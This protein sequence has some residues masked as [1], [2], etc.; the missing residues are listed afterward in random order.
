M[1]GFDQFNLR[2]DVIQG[3]DAMR[4]QNPTPIQIQAIPAIME[5]RD[6]MGCAQ[7]GTGKTAAYILPVL[8]HLL[9]KK[10]DISKISTL[11]IVPT[12]ELALQI[13]QQLEGFSYFLNIS[14]ISVY[15]GGDSGSWEQQKTALT[16]GVEIVI[17]TPGRL[18][19]HLN[20]GYVDFTNL[21]FLILDEADRMLDMGFFDDIVKIL[22]FLPLKRQNLM[23]SATMPP[24]IKKL[25]RDILVNPLHINI[26]ASKPAEGVIQAVY[27]L[28]ENQKLDKISKLFTGKDISGAIIFASSKI[29]VK[30]ITGKLKGLDLNV[31]AIHSDLEQ[32]ERETVMRDFKNRKIQILVAT[33]IIS[34][35]IDVEGLDLVINYDVP[36]D[37]EDYIHRVG[38]TARAHKSGVAITFVTPRDT[39]DLQKIERFLGNTIYKIPD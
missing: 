18:M 13:D 17:A 37:P 6:I 29:R 24:K 25:A 33:D 34:R 15:G 36:R 10:S 20:L 21:D 11:I 4:Y 1:T 39:R 8:N 12:R 26:A 28:K 9:S 22:D 7:T 35:G 19:S 2:E 23:F 32:K 30:E 27:M 5:G 14:F 38:R 31:K 3:I 16:T